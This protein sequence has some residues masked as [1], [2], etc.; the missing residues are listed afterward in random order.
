MAT[1]DATADPIVI[2]GLGAVSAL[3]RGC[4]ALWGAI[5]EGRDGI[6]SLGRFS[7][8][9]LG[10]H[11]AATVPGAG[12]AG[13][14]R[15]E[16]LCLDFALGA[17]REAWEGARVDHAG[18]SGDRIA[19]VMGTS[20]GSHRVELHGLVEELGD[21]LGVSG[22]RIT[23]STACTSS[24]NAVGLASDL[25]LA[26]EAD[27]L[28]AGGADSIT[29][30]MFAGFHALDVLCPEPC[31]PFSHPIGMTLGEGAGFV[32]LER[33]S[34]CGSRGVRPRA[35]LL[36]YGLSSD[37]YHE[38][39][40]EPTGA[41]VARAILGALGFAGLS[42]VDVQYVNAHGTGTAANDAA[43][44]QALQ[45]VFGTGGGRSAVSSSKASI[46]HAQAA[47]GI[48]ETIL[49]VLALE[50]QRLPPTLRFKGA[51]PRCPADPVGGPLPR[52]HPIEVAVCTNSAFGGANAALVL[53]RAGARSAPAAGPPA[54]SSDG[55]PAPLRR[56][57]VLGAGVVA[58]SGLGAEALEAA[59]AGGA[60]LPPEVPA[61]AV[62]KL[63]RRADP[64]L[65][66][67][68]ARLL[69]A[70]TALALEDAGVRLEGRSRDRAGIVVGA[71]RLSPE[72]S[73]QLAASVQEGGLAGISAHAF[74]RSVLHASAGSCSATFGLRGPSSTVAAGD[75]SGL[76]AIL[77]AAWL[78]RDHPDAELLVAGG[79][80]ERDPDD[81]RT[82]SEGAG[83]LVL[84]RPAAGS[85]PGGPASAPGVEL[86]GWA[87][88]GPGREEHAVARAIA[89]AGSSRGRI[90]LE[91]RVGVPG[92]PLLAAIGDARA[93]LGAIACALAARALGRGPCRSA[94]VVE[95][96]SRSVTCALVLERG[97]EG[98]P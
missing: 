26:G 75:A 9:G 65:L 49:T 16:E 68:T 59:L 80:H 47:A 73:R 53:G 63:A 57:R 22:P 48:L 89:N 91:V 58:P 25:L 30:E 15:G 31:A 2:S 88:A 51:R 77:V 52:P 14:P 74:A 83:C 39:S 33:A 81:P 56:V 38:T 10:V 36:G 92:D 50:H 20:L 21:R 34:R 69:T 41:G 78:L 54:R 40:P 23:I 55:R 62:E 27:L 1:Q 37:A 84:G 13:A 43:E 94:L 79:V 96:R 66:D 3:G 71:G 76:L 85:A 60:R 12:G 32:V 44:W 7:T 42:A 97:L 64:R 5:L 46:G 4:G 6:S 95:G 24:T 11:L 70:A 90:D 82:S 29:P 28:L 98:E 18:I 72:S 17:A 45:R 86:A 67:R 93:A 61:F 19:L 8:E 87:V 35:R